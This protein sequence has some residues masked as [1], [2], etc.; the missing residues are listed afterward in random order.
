MG[1]ASTLYGKLDM[2][3]ETYGFVSTMMNAYAAYT[4]APYLK[5]PPPAPVNPW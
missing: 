2:F 5:A 4:K 1:F 3:R